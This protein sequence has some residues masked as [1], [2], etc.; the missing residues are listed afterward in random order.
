M[1]ATFQE[2]SNGITNSH[3]ISQL[4]I[5]YTD[6]DIYKILHLKQLK[7]L[8]LGLWRLDTT[9]HLNEKEVFM[10]IIDA[11]PNLET[12]IYPIKIY[13]NANDDRF[14][15]LIGEIEKNRQILIVTLLEYPVNS[16]SKIK[17]Y[18]EKYGFSYKE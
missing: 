8:D 16:F 6:I 1:V 18:G 15:S 4:I 12:I 9:E 11:L 13:R 14:K 2:P 7:I 5:P 17:I 3:L 10:S